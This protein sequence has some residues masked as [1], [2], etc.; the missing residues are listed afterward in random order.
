MNKFLVTGNLVK[1][2]E[3]K[4]VPSTG[5]A[6]CKFTIANN[7]GWGEKKTISYLNCT[8]FGGTAEAIA[9]YTHRG[10]KVLIDGKLQTGSYDKKD[11]TGKVYT[12]D[13]IVNFIEFLDKKADGKPTHEQQV[14]N[15]TFDNAFDDDDIFEPMDESNLDSIPF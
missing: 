4:F 9:N 10:S 1:D 11:G 14:D 5:M 8:A 12:T 15:G 2:S 7:E 3:L 6:V 13:V